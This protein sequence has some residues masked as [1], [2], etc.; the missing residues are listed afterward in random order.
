MEKTSIYIHTSSYQINELKN[1][2]IYKLSNF[3]V[4]RD[5]V[6][7]PIKKTKEDLGHFRFKV[8]FFQTFS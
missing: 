5:L 4:Q 2:L 7:E 3:N 6:Y 8:N 1:F